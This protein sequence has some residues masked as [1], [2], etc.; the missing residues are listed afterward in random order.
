MTYNVFGAT[1]TLLNATCHCRHHHQRPHSAIDWLFLWEQKSASVWWRPQWNSVPAWPQRDIQLYGRLYVQCTATDGRHCCLVRNT[2]WQCSSSLM[3]LCNLVDVCKMEHITFVSVRSAPII[4]SNTVSVF[5]CEVSKSKVY[6]KLFIYFWVKEN[7][8]F[9]PG[10]MELAEPF[11]ANPSRRKKTLIS[12]RAR[13]GALR[14][15]LAMLLVPGHPT[16]PRL[17]S[18]LPGTLQLWVF[19]EYVIQ[20]LDRHGASS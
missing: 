17:P 20:C 4:K 12:T 7:S 1:L 13:W 18:E 3:A 8:D 15:V 2:C 14:A 19:Y 16:Y 6:I 5:V 10:Q 9:K 11:Q